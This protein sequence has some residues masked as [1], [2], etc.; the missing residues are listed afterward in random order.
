MLSSLR[1]EVSALSGDLRMAKVKLE[2]IMSLLS[3]VTSG[4][5]ETTPSNNNRGTAV[6][7]GDGGGSAFEGDD[8][9]GSA[10]APA[11][12]VHGGGFGFGGWVGGDRESGGGIHRRNHDRSVRGARPGFFAGQYLPMGHQQQAG[13]HPFYP[14]PHQTP[15]ST[16]QYTVGPNQVSEQIRLSCEQIPKSMDYSSS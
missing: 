16:E 11:E 3:Y 7:G 10:A 6:G 14:S 4:H 5:N 13:N 15:S 1:A 9:V 12:N 2:N 8:V